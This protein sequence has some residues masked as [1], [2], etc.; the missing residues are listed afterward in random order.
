MEYTLKQTPESIW[1]KV[2]PTPQK[3]HNLRLYLQITASTKESRN[4]SDNFS[5]LYLRRFLSPD[6]NYYVII[7]RLSQRFALNNHII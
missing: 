1:A 5:K 6:R 4:S 7:R 2:I 3:D